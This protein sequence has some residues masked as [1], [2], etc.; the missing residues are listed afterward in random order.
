MDAVLG[1]REK[2]NELRKAPRSYR[3]L[4]LQDRRKS[5][6]PEIIVACAPYFLG[7]NEMRHLRK[8]G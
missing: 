1:E 7:H 4:F 2:V 5:D 6:R 3:S 8:F